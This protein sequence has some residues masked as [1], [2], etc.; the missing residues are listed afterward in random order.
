[1]SLKQCK[2]VAEVLFK[3]EPVMA[4]RFKEV[5]TEFVDEG[6][7]EESVW[8]LYEAFVLGYIDAYKTK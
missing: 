1:M 2:A 8:D 6:F 7:G 4:K 3:E 5:I